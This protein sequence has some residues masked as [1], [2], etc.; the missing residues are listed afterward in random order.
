M[1]ILLNGFCLSLSAHSAAGC[2]IECPDPSDME[3]LR[4][5][6]A[7][8]W[9]LYWRGG[10]AFGLP[11][12]D[13]PRPSSAATCTLDFGDLD[14]LHLLA[15][16]IGEVLPTLFPGYNPFRSR[17]RTF[18]FLARKQDTEIVGRVTKGWRDPHPLLGRFTIR[19]R[20]DLEPRIVEPRPGETSIGL[21]L[22]VVTRWQIQAT[23]QEL[24]A[25][26][27]DLTGL[28]VVRRAPLPQQRSLVGTIEKLMGDVVVLKE[29]LDGSRSVAADDVWVEGSRA[30][31]TR[32]LHHLLGSRYESLESGRFSE[33]GKLFAGPD[34][35]RLITE[36]EVYLKAKGDVPLGAGLSFRVQGRV[37]LTNADGF[38]SV[39]TCGDAEYCFDAAKSKRHPYSWKGLLRY[40]PFD[41]DSFSKRSPRILVVCPEQAAG[42]VSAF[43]GHFKN[44]IASVPSSQ[45][46][47]GFAATFGLANPSFVSLPVRLLGVAE[48]RVA[49]AYRAAIEARLASAQEAFDAAF[50]VLDD[51]HGRLP[52]A[53]N[54]YLHAKAVL[55]LHGI[56]S[57]QC[58]LSTASAPERDLHWKLPNVAVAMYAKLGGSPWTVAQSQTADD[59]LVI[60]MGMAEM[61]GS[62]FDARHRY[63]G[64]TTVFR[65]DGNY[66]LSNVSR[67]CDYERYPEE[68]RQTTTAL[69]AELRE[70]NGWR[71]GD[72]VRIVFH[73][74]K[75]LK[76]VEV[77]SIVGDCVAEVGRDVNIEFAFLTVE[78][79]HPFRLFDTDQ[80]GVETKG[81]R[82]VKGAFSPRRGT[83]AQLGRHTRLLANNGPLQVKRVGAPLPAPLLIH[84]HRES[85]YV[86]L[87]YLTEQVLKFTSL[88]WRSTLPASAPVTIY[89]SELIAEQLCRL[90]AVPDWSPALLN[91]K[92]KF[93]RWFL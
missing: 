75:P 53:V 20:F 83:I 76:N 50:V 79:S 23:V 54:P 85:R 13:S 15:A 89:Y 57:Q 47:K 30:S 22:S 58:R 91:T 35:D 67:V 29:S 84:L 48:G 56:P 39:R 93:S 38:Q 17:R 73:A 87:D 86:D 31:F 8:K 46:Q 81:G 68:L 28:A 6:Q 60:G 7:G 74:R 43:V 62:R 12:A 18:S 44:G 2:V 10:R 51:A 71:A 64:I 26:G 42:R 21:F 36:M 24:A 52:D 78:T 33:E 27:V 66:L 88:T 5:Q 70:R 80:P 32:C 90:Q 37:A 77:A 1:P 4:A 40:G 45:Y 3:E 92:L 11:L 49:A 59:E 41:R 34:L 25:A 14:T 55:L 69:L 16:R 19:P 9:F 72:T 61:S 82:G 63:T 65:G